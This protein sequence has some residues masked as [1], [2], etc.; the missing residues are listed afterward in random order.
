MFLNDV[1][2]YK[3]E[4]RGLGLNK[5]ILFDCKSEK[6]TAWRARKV[7]IFVYPKGFSQFQNIP[8]SNICNQSQGWIPPPPLRPTPRPNE[9]KCCAVLMVQPKVQPKDYVTAQ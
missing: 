8:L 6:R 2:G 1:V 9:R 3:S 5:R 4:F 7:D